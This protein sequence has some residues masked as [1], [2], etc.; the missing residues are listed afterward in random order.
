[1]Q[2]FTIF[3]NPVSH[4]K[5]PQMHNNGFKNLNIDAKYTRTRLDDGKDIKSKIESIKISGA[6]VTVP[7]KEDAYNL[8]DEVIGVANSIKA[9]NTI[10]NKDGKLYGY[11]T[12]A[13]GFYK[14]IEEFGDIKKA[15]ILGA[16]GTAKSIAVIF[17]EKNIDFDILNRSANRLDFFKELNIDAYSWDNFVADEYDLVINTTSAGLSDG[18]LPIEE[19]LLTSMMQKA[20]F[21][22]DVIYGKDTPF[23]THAKKMNLITKDGKDMLLYQGVL[24]FELFTGGKYSQDEI[25]K[26]LK[27]GLELS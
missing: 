26:Y 9:I 6:N 22:I 14:S 1:M 23:L 21:A 19:S 13:E 16:G 27:E 4:S 3:G 24:A 15:L 8:V 18:S 10:I 7:F 17:K 11:N 2:I 25:T 12:D 5:S 20:K